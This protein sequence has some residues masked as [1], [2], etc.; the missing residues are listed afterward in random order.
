MK[1][2]LRTAILVLGCLL[3]VPL[4]VAAQADTH[5][6]RNAQPIRVRASDADRA[7]IQERKEQFKEKVS[8][9]RQKLLKDRCVKAQA[10]L[11]RRLSKTATVRVAREDA[12]S[13]LTNR[14]DAFILRLE[15]HGLDSGPLEQATEEVEDH[16][17][18]FF[19]NFDT[20]QSALN[21]AIIM[22]CREDPVAFQAALEE[23]RAQ[24]KALVKEAAAIRKLV[25]Q[26][27]K[28]HFATIRNELAAKTE[29]AQ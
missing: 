4:H 15:N 18:E 12:Y 16:I 25:G 20:Y 6:T 21:D 28:N 26:T 8:A 29:E 27:I 7:R 19:A 17:K 5:T 14:L 2:S 13:R 11:Q 1:I 10:R 23:A 9:S 24:R 3:F 22:D